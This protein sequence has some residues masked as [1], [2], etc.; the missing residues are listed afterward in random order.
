MEWTPLGIESAKQFEDLSPAVHEEDGE[1]DFVHSVALTPNGCMHDLT[2]FSVSSTERGLLRGRARFIAAQ[3]R[4]IAA[5]SQHALACLS[6]GSDGAQVITSPGTNPNP[7]R[8]SSDAIAAAV[9]EGDLVSDQVRSR[10]RREVSR[11]AGQAWEED[12][13]LRPGGRTPV[14]F[15]RHLASINEG[16]QA[17]VK[18]YAQ[19]KL[20][21]VRG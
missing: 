20:A 17:A 1:I 8:I 19:L 5:R 9:V 3:E 11:Q 16:A 14:E 18:S 21:P 2:F 12:Q 10:L 4:E 13:K 6:G 15:A 7:Q